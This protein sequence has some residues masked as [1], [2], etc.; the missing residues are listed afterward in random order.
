MQIYLDIEPDDLTAAWRLLERHG[1]PDERTVAT[2][3][4]RGKIRSDGREL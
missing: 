4:G 2:E 1:R 3:T